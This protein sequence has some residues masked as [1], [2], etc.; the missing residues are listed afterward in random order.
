[1]SYAIEIRVSLVLFSGNLEMGASFL[2]LG[3]RRNKLL[4]VFCLENFL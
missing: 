4:V 1:V 3:K 2:L